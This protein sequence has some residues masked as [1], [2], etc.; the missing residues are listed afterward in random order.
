MTFFLWLKNSDSNSDSSNTDH[1]NSDSSNSDRINSD[2]SNSDGSISD[3]NNI[4][5]SKNEWLS[6]WMTKILWLKF[7]DWNFV[8]KFL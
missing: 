7:C 8:S 6:G 1:S 3:V 4:D 5:S 2:S